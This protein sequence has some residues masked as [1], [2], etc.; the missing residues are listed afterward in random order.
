VEWSIPLAA[1]GSP[2]GCF[3]I[4][5]Y[6]CSFYG[7]MTNQSLPPMTGAPCTPGPAGNFDFS[8]HGGASSVTVCPGSVPVRAGTW[9]SLKAA[10]R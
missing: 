2:A 3:K 4:L 6:A 5:V 7:A 1:I 9:G 8:A 10:Y